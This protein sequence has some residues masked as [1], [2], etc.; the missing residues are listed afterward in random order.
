[1][2]I[3]ELQNIEKSFGKRKILDDISMNI[4]QGDIIGIMGR[5]GSGKTTLLNIIGLLDKSDSG[6]YL[7]NEHAVNIKD[8][9][10]V[11]NI[12][13][14]HIGFVIQNY[15]L[16]NEKN[17]FY[18]ISVPLLCKKL[19]K[20]DIKKQV[21]NIAKKIGISE[22][23]DKYPYELSGGECQ[24]VSIARALV[25]QPS[26]ILAD[27]PT[28]A[29]DEKTEK[30][31]LTLFKELNNQGTTILLVTHNQEV[32]EICKTLYK[33]KEGKLELIYG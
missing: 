4:Y 14:D 31:I 20:K 32:S 12:R 2:K 28:G 3:I 33:I 30:E 22:L 21:V 13:R 15:A 17:V 19:N 11:S 27:E 25:R 7:L 16:I 6:K 9:K 18:N 5:S 24:R 23:L 29:L 26:I 8:E 10:V 1:M